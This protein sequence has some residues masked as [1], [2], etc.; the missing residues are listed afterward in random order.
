MRL[1]TVVIL[2]IFFPSIF[3]Y[4]QQG[5]KTYILD[6]KRNLNIQI[7]EDS[8]KSQLYFTGAVYTNAT[9][10]MP[11][12]IERIPVSSG[13][14]TAT[15]VLKNTVYQPVSENIRDMDGIESV[16]DSIIIRHYPSL[17]RSVPYLVYSFVPIRKNPVTGNYEKL[18]SFIPDIK[19]IAGESNFVKSEKV[20]KTSSVL[21]TGNWYKISIQNTG[22]YKVTYQDLSNMGIDVN[23]I[24]PRN[25]RLYGNGGGM[26]PEQLSLFRHDDLEENAIQVEGENDGRFDQGDYI[27]FYGEGPHTWKYNPTTHS[28]NHVFNIYSDNAFYFLTTDLGP[29]KRIGTQASSTSP[30]TNTV[31]RFTDYAFHELDEYNLVNT[32]RVWYGEVF[33][34]KTS[35][36]YNLTF[37]DLDATSPGYFKAYVAAKSSIMSYFK[38]Y[39]N[40]SQILTGSINSIPSSSTTFARNYVG[41]VSFIP[42]GPQIDVKISYQKTTS[43][44]MGWLNYFEL[45]VV[46]FLKFSGGQLSFRNPASAG[47]GNITEF[48][49]SNANADVQLWNVT[50]AQNVMKVTA[51]Q[52]GNQKVFRLANDSLL[53]F[54]A[55]DG[56]IFNTVTFAGK[57]ENQNLHG[58]G[59]VDMVIL[60]HPSFI[61]EANRLAAYH[62]E[63]DG[64]RI[65]VTEPQIIYNEFS[66]GAQDI[67]AIRDF[68]KMLYDEAPPAQKPK[69]LLLF[70]DASFDYKDRIQNNSN[71]VPTWEDN[72]SLTIEYSIVTDDFYGFMDTGGAPDLLD[73][74]IGRLPV[75]TLDQATV[76]VNKILNYTSNSGSVMGDWRNV[77][78]FVADDADGN[79]HFDQAEDMVRFI[80]TTY[81]QYNI[82][83]IYVDA[84]PQVSTPGGQRAPEVNKAI[85]NRIAKGTLIMN[86]TGHGG[87]VGWGHERFL[88]ISDIN[89]WTNINMLPIFIT[90]TCEFSRY[91]DPTRVS[92]GELVC[93]NP[94]GGSIGMFTTARATFGGSNFNLNLD[95]FEI[96]FEKEN[97]EYYRFGDLIRL[98]KNKSGAVDNDRKFVLLGDP[99]VKLAYP[100]F[101]VATTS[102]N[103][104]PVSP[105]PDTLK[106]LGKVIVKGEVRDA[107][108][109]KLNSYNGTIVPIVFDKPSLI[110][111]LGTD[112]E[113][114]KDIFE[115][116][117]NILYKGNANVTNGEFSFSFIVPK[118]IA[119]KYGFGKI[120]YY[121]TGNETDANGFYKNLVI[122]GFDETAEPDINGPDVRLFMNDSLFKFGGITDENPVLVA[123]VRDESGINTVGS[124]I[125][126]DIVA[127]LDENTDRPFV[128]NG[129]Y[130][131]DLNSY[132]SGT[133]TYPFS[134][135][136]KG[137]HS[138]RLKAWDVFNNSGE[139]YTEFF[140]A[141]SGILVI[142]NAMNYPNPLQSGTNF[143]FEHNRPETKLNVQIQIFNVAGVLAKTIET[144]VTTAG[145]RSPPIYWDG[146][147]DSG[148]RIAQG[149]YVYRIVVHSS[150]GSTAAKT[151]KLII[152]N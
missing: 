39:I 42:P 119:Y 91:D 67:S 40:N 69:Y 150:D 127:I 88:E 45:N 70:G 64:L 135:L 102:L 117:N 136:S 37:P 144:A 81:S 19:I 83:K 80:D 33:D 41:D 66:S 142:D 89:S 35:Y 14:I 43:N 124:G 7:S 122:G 17:D 16:G 12:F 152:L 99:A 96:M 112:P 139:G 56:S 13:D 90:A 8:V 128:L 29:G 145:Y 95:M 123:Y 82:D 138:L 55:F 74:G 132:S 53:E 60:T 68:M 36:D 73:I 103:S 101:N 5:E 77:I 20:Y 75:G 71:F 48:T 76:V 92:A 32:G 129:Y 46:R 52:N 25:I 78:T 63:K 1:R 114:H 65:L 72:E 98:A 38:F 151:Q 61:N 110:S 51:A 49:L 10:E 104:V 18:V 22:I 11:V 2:I 125:G 109:N 100:E 93:L 31:D 85:N 106:A 84:F 105:N 54:S 30:P 50:D 79:M 147:D 116:Q 9:R 131:S 87:E 141:D 62:E 143:V 24:D 121:S 115:L 59:P 148:G 27:L 44:S 113:S 26:L 149:L 15:I 47:M 86:Y 3:G 58:I 108:G 111:T 97:G 23:N 137:L 21:A 126:H 120:S 28:F 4:S 94:A 140:V 133:V 146:R 130:Q 57:I 6:W 34:V 107:S 134:N 118:D